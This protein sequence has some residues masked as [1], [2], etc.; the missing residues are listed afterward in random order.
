[1][2]PGGGV[3]GGDVTGGTP[4]P[5]PGR[6]R[7]LLPGPRRL[8]LQV[9]LDLLEELAHGGAGQGALGREYRNGSTGTGTP[10]QDRS[11]EDG[12]TG[13]GSP[14]RERGRRAPPLFRPALTVTGTGRDR[15]GAT[16]GARDTGITEITGITGGW[17]HLRIPYRQLRTPERDLRTSTKAPVASVKP[18]RHPR[19]LTEPR[20]AAPDRHPQPSRNSLGS[21]CE[22]SRLRGALGNSGANLAQGWDTAGAGGV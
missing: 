17:R 3:T 14:A 22:Q 2:V 6:L 19:S 16:W 9:G 13:T 20:P 10:E 1:M 15:P 21:R 8:E 18:G 7:E 5:V 11:T 12:S 4:Q